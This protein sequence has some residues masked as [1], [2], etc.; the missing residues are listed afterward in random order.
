MVQE[1]GT[2]LENAI[3]RRDYWAQAAR[4]AAAS[5]EPSQAAYAHMF[6]RH[7]EK[8]L[9]DLREQRKAA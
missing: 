1:P 7:Y 2:E 5:G 8:I 3:E 4:T 9:E 6:V